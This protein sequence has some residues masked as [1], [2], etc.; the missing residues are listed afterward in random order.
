MFGGN[1][2]G[3]WDDV[4]SPRRRGKGLGLT[5]EGSQIC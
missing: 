3:G 5:I 1:E 2:K 4:F